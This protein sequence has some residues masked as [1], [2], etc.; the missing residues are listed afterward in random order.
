MLRHP[1]DVDSSLTYQVVNPDDRYTG[2]L[3]FYEQFGATPGDEN[4]FLICPIVDEQEA[5]RPPLESD[6]LFEAVVAYFVAGAYRLALD[7]FAKFNDPDHL[8]RA[9]TMIVQASSQQIDHKSLADAI[10]ERFFGEE[11]NHGVVRFDWARVEPLFAGNEDTWHTW[12]K[13]FESSRRTIEGKIPHRPSVPA[14][15]V[16]WADVRTR[17]A[18]AVNNTKLRVVIGTLMRARL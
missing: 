13:S 14:A 5:G 16:L 1:S 9:H 12:Y 8:P 10:R 4:N 15:V 11:D 18:D 6:S 17:L 2:S 7:P 3:C